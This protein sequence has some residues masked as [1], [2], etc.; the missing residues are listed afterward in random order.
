MKDERFEGG[1]APSTWE[2]GTKVPRVGVAGSVADVGGLAAEMS[3]LRLRVGGP[4]QG[5]EVLLFN[6]LSTSGLMLPVRHTLRE[7]VEEVVECRVAKEK[8][9]VIQLKELLTNDEV[10]SNLAMKLVAAEKGRAEVQELADHY[11]MRLIRFQEGVKVAGVEMKR[12]LQE[13]F[14]LR[15]KIERLKSGKVARGVDK[16]TRMSTEAVRPSFCLAGVQTEVAEVS[17][18]GVMTD[19]INV[20]VV[21]KT[22]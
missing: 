8:A 15:N 4:S 17:T 10:S 21:R 9:E 2:A 1:W 18:I 16:G 13:G 5:L 3:Q 19:V 14:D 20:Q 7:L 6:L 22:T 12:L 11:G